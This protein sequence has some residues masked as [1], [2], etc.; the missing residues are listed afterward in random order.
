MGID[1]TEGGSVL[2]L[3]VEIES[4]ND[5]NYVSKV[6]YCASTAVYGRLDPDKISVLREGRVD[7]DKVHDALGLDSSLDFN[8]LITG[9]DGTVLL[10]FG[11]SPVGRDVVS[12][13]KRVIDVYSFDEACELTVRIF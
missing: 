2:S 8:L 13:Y 11:M 1:S 7:Y 9:F 5:N 4:V 12:Y 6:E 3:N 10:N